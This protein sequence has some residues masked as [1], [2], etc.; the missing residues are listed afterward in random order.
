MPPRRAKLPTCVLVAATPLLLGAPAAAQATGEGFASYRTSTA[1]QA[2]LGMSS[3][4][5]APID[6]FALAISPPEGYEELPGAPVTGHVL[7]LGAGLT[8][9][10]ARLVLGLTDVVLSPIPM[11]PVSPALRFGFS[12]DL[13]HEREEDP[14]WL[15]DLDGWG[16]EAPS[17]GYRLGV[18]ACFPWKGSAAAEEER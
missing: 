6:P 18:L 8:L 12:P 5:G 17:W 2:L 16:E 1:N 11:L 13:A 14:E 15:C 4:L 7:G 3:V 10:L 9:G